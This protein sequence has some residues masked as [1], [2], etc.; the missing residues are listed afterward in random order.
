[1]NSC[2]SNCHH[3]A[4]FQQEIHWLNK[5]RVNFFS[6]LTFI[7]S[8]GYKTPFLLPHVFKVVYNIQNVFIVEPYCMWNHR[9]ESLALLFHSLFF[10]LRFAD[11]T[12]RWRRSSTPIS[13]CRCPPPCPPPSSTAWQSTAPPSCRTSTGTHSACG[14]EMNLRL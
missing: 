9:W 6:F 1:M 11:W 10:A 3:V 5:K 8:C 13:F 2:I 4:D 14:P 12:R 7:P